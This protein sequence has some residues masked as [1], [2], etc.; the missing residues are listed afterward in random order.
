MIRPLKFFS[1]SLLICLI[2]LFMIIPVLA[3]PALPSS[4]YGTIKVKG[5]NVPDGT[6]VEALISGQVYAKGYTQTYQG[7]SVYAL[8]IPGD[9]TDTT[10]QDGGRE[11]DT[12]QFKIGGLLADETGIWKG[13][14]NVNLNLNLTAVVGGIAGPQAT[15]SPMPTQT[16]IAIIQSSPVPTQTSAAGPISTQTTA[17]LI[18]A[19]PN[20]TQTPVGR[21]Q[22]VQSTQMAALPNE[23]STIPTAFIPSTDSKNNPG[24]SQ[25]IIAAVIIASV[26]I[27]SVLFAFRRKL[28]ILGKSS[29]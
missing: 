23:S 5:N 16:A 6:L 28:T 25:P 2:S 22:S 3:M 14:T 12:I 4:F 1:L 26:V 8:D 10:V 24:N 17:A 13:A 20:P 7:A 15:P 21:I 27:G 29:K 9:D 11:G 19:S 18:Q